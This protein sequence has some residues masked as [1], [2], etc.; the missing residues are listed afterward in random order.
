MDRND[1]ME[2]AFKSSRTNVDPV[3][4]NEVPLGATAKEVRDDV[5]AMLSE[6]EYVVP[7][8]V[9]RYFGVRFFE[10]LRNK[11]KDGMVELEQ[12]G[13]I[14][15]EPI[16]EDME[17]LPF[18]ISE[19]EVIDVEDD[20]E[21]TNKE[22]V[23]FAE[24]GLNADVATMDTPDFLQG[25]STS[26]SSGEQD[27][28]TYVGPGGQIMT[29]RFVDGKP[30]SYIP[31][32]YVLQG[33][34]TGEPQVKASKSS[35]DSGSTSPVGRAASVANSVTPDTPV[36]T[37]DAVLS[38]SMYDGMSVE[39]LTDI[40]NRSTNLGKASSLVQRLNPVLG[41]ATSAAAKIQEQALA[42]AAQSGYMNATSD[43][44]KQGYKNL[45]DQITTGGK[46]KGSGI[47]G[48]GGL[49]GGG[50]TLRDTNK[51]GSVSFGD[52]ALG[53]LLGFDGKVG[54]QGASISDSLAGA[55]R[56][57]GTGSKSSSLGSS[58]SSKNTYTQDKDK[59]GGFFGGKTFGETNLGKALG[60]GKDDD[61]K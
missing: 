39:E 14:G 37:G 30:M 18:D 25:V 8:D 1:Q 16:E 34:E 55:R 26:F 29:V 6:N 58:S 41:L 5:P 49:M 32:G 42:R 15:G 56:T 59:G 9:V 21:D 47:F 43:V 45:F 44:D 22:V 3:S 53:D 60:F 40:A 48:G 13:R 4:G 28:R 11:A 10:D 35:Q 31:P 17:D 52:T 19:L 50:G 2:A 33:T 36:D 7:A 12:G 27:I 61:E 54:L 23:G 38:E 57:G 51:D 24:G 20:V 46:D